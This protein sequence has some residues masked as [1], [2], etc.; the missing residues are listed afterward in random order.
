MAAVSF[1]SIAVIAALSAGT[2]LALSSAADA[3]G[4]AHRNRAWV[5]AR[6]A[7]VTQ[8]VIPGN[9]MGLSW[10]DQRAAAYEAC[11]QNGGYL[12]GAF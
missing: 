7:R 3:E 5:A 11:L 4:Y 8:D 12:A 2:V 10:P 6:C 9:Y 1:K